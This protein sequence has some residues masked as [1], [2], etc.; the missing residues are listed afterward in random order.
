MICI[1]VTA[2]TQAEALQ[3][4]EKILPFADV[5]ELRMDLI[6]DGNLN[7]L[8]TRCKSSP[9]PLK[10]LVTNRV[11]GFSP[12]GTSE[13]PDQQNGPGRD[14]FCL[15][16]VRRDSEH[17][18]G[19]RQRIAVL[20][21]AVIL[22][23]DYIDVELDTPEYL[24]R[25][26]A[27]L[28]EETGKRTKL[29][30]SHHD[31]Q[32]T[33]SVEA[34]KKVF[35]RCVQ[36]GA[37]IVKIVTFARRPEDNLRILNLVSYASDRSQEI[38]AF[39]MGDQGRISRVMAPFLGSCLNF[40]SL[41]RGAESAPGQFTVSEM[42]KIM[43]L[44]SGAC[45]GENQLPV[46]SRTKMFALFGNPV[47]QSLS[48]LMH[49]ATLAAMNVDG[50]YMAFCIHDL[51]SA[52]SGIRGMGIRGVSVTIPFKT[53]VMAHLDEI[54]ADAL[55]IRAV[56]TIV[57]ENGRLKGYNTDWM[58]LVQSLEDEMGIKGKRF[59]IIGA[60]GTARAAVFGILKAGGIPAVVSRNIE[61]GQG[62]AQE[63]GCSFHPLSDIGKVRADCLVN[64]T[65][66]GMI[67][68][69]D[70]SPVNGSVLSNYRWVM[71]AVY[72]PLKT[73]L[74]RDAQK[75]GCAVLPGLGMFIHQGAEQIK[76]WTG[77]EPPRPFM[78]S[79]VEEYLMHG[80]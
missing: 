52:I 73:K 40:A 53:A 51:V 32:R 12:D 15:P 43:K 66:V 7:S 26:L 17:A 38:I 41:A 62:L 61:R 47:K 71:D 44:A 59:A 5:V 23:A 27:S 10:I 63:W 21:E 54:D 70:E 4:V 69:V 72:N 37:G 67:P 13:P 19:E 75:E 76:L 46:S 60:G 79:V 6:R 48:P 22:G 58:G 14:P 45:L 35:H 64:T 77:L 28:I 11:R 18:S 1:P 49:N 34:L 31:Y 20:K 42:K 3:Q 29:I 8:V 57:N 30:V 33:P 80:N 24:R 74:L 55:E 16:F 9:V 50:R 39:C 2:Q 68:N 36:A 78:K 25:E 56:N 65:P